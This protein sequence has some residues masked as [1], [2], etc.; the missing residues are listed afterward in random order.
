[1]GV[2]RIGKEGAP[3]SLLASVSALAVQ[4][5]GNSFKDPGQNRLGRDIAPG[6]TICHYRTTKVYLA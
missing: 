6:P 2:T 5:G 1:M 4:G 3:H